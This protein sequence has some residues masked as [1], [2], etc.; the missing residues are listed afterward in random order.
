M[1][2]IKKG[3]WDSKVQDD[4]Y[5]GQPIRYPVEEAGKWEPLE[6]ESYLEALLTPVY[7]QDAYDHGVE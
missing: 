2:G 6:R 5:P 1:T 7:P 3:V 4:V